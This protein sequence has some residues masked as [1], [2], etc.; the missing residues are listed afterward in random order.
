[1]TEFEAPR[2]SG[3]SDGWK[4]GYLV[5]GGIEQA[6]MGGLSVKAEY[7]YVS[8]SGLKANLPFGGVAESD[9]DH[10]VKVGLNYRF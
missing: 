3:V 6:F 5:G 10:V 8:S 2:L 7:N 4:G 1:M 9:G